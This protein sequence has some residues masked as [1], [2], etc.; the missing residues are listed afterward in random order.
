M[1]YR[2]LMT[3]TKKSFIREFKLRKA[4]R[5]L[6]KHGDQ[7]MLFN[8]VY[9]VLSTPE[10]QQT[11]LRDERGNKLALPTHKLS[12]MYDRGH[13]KK[14]NDFGMFKA[15]PSEPVGVIKVNSKG[16]PM[17]KVVNPKGG[18]MWI[19]IKKNTVHQDHEGGATDHS[20]PSHV[21]G[22]VS[23]S[24]KIEEYA[25]KGAWDKLKD[26]LKKYVQASVAYNHMTAAAHMNHEAVQVAENKGH[27]AEELKRRF[28]K[29][30]KNSLKERKKNAST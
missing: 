28:K 21:R 25:E 22:I 6:F 16:E 8:N 27:E 14:A 9:K 1:D 12:S 26:L 11:I 4:N 3:K 18:T 2:K 29:E 17:M 7:L 10:A 24:S 20:E 30:F 15:K 5:G 23:V 13:V 19:H